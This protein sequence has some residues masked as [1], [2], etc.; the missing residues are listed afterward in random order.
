MTLQNHTEA[1]RRVW[2]DY[3]KSFEDGSVGCLYPSESLVR[4]VSTIRKGI[5]LDSSSYF[6]VQGSENS[7]RSNFSGRALELGFGHLSN[8]RMMRDKGF[9]CTG[10]E[11]SQD[12][13]DR[14]N[15][16]LMASK[17]PGIDVS[18]WSDL[19]KLPFDNS[20]FDFV[21][22]LQCIYYNVD[23]TNIISE[24]H[25]ILKPGGHFAFSFFSNDHDY[26]K[27]IDV[28]Q[29]KDNYQVVAW[30]KDH[31]SYRIRGAVLAQPKSEEC[32]LNLFSS[33]SNT[34]IFREESTFSPLFESWWFIYGQR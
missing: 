19:T 13:V 24:V 29:D 6:D 4:V 20:T 1:S 5:H 15:A 2:D 23:I 8:L 21:Y 28:L 7:I 3:Y 18:F 30:S 17:E 31:P 16:Q 33:F 22:G 9:A 25:R 12:S 27:F 10:L 32:L 14:A 11:V 34:R 26:T